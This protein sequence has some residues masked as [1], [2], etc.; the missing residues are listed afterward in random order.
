MLW[1]FVYNLLSYLILFSDKRRK[2]FYDISI[3]SDKELRGLS[4][5][6]TKLAKSF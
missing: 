5:F 6:L 3:S 4:I 1:D 2:D